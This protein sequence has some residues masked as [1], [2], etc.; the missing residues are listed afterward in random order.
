MKKKKL[1]K[2]MSV[3]LSAAMLA[4]SV[5]TGV[6]AAAPEVQTSQEKAADENELKLWYDEKAPDSYE[7]WYRRALP[8]GNSGIGASVFGGITE[9]RIQLNEKS[10]WSGGPSSSRN[11]NGGNIETS[12]GVKMSDIVTQIQ[13]A[14][15]NGEVD[16]GSNNNTIKNLCNKLVGLSDDAGTNG[17]GYYLSYG[18]MYLDFKGITESYVSNYKRALDLH[19]AVASVEYDYNGTHYVRENF[20]SYPDNVLVTRLTATGGS[21]KLNFDVKVNPDDKKG[22][23]ANN[24]GASSYQRDWT[25]TVKGGEI[26]VAGALKD[27]QMKFN[28]QT[29]VI[30][31]DGTTTDGT[32]KVTVADATSVTIIT[33]IATDYKDEYPKYRTDESADVL[34]TRVGSYVSKAAAKDYDTLKA[35][36]VADYQNIF[37]RVD[38]DLGQI[39]SDKTTD[40]LLSAYKA[41]TATDAE[42]RYLEVMLFQY[43][44]YLTIE[45]SRETPEDDP[46]R[47]T[48][49]SNLQGIWS[50]AN[51]SPWHSD[52]HMNVNL[53]M[54]YW[55]TYVTNM[56]E[57]AEPLIDYVDALRAPGRVT[58]KIYA[59]VESKDGEENGFM[60]HTQ[61]NPFGWTCPGWSFSWGWSPAAVPWI[62]QNCW[63][64]Y[65]FTRDADYLKDKIYPMM[66]E[67]ATFYDQILIEDADG[68]LVSSPSYSPEH[69]RYTSGNTYEQTLVWQ[70][71]EDTI[72]AAG[73][74]GETNTDK[75][76]K[77]K[78]NQSNLKGPIEVGKSGQ[79]KEWYNETTFNKDENG[80]NLGEGYGHRHIS[81][82]LGLFPG[83]LITA[84]KADWF[85]A[86]KVSMENRTDESTGW[87]MAQRINTWARLGEG[88][89]AYEIIKNQFK[90]GIYENLFDYHQPN[91]FQIDGNFGYTSGVAEMLLQSNMG[92]INLLPALPDTWSDGS[93]EGLVARGNFELSYNWSDG[94]LNQAQILSNKGGECQVQYSGI[95]KA[96]VTDSEGNVV[97]ATKVD[98]KTNRIS[99]NT[100]A[101]KTYTIKVPEAPKNVKANYYGKS[102]T[103]VSWS[104]V[105]DATSYNVYR[106]E[107]GM[108]F[109]KVAENTKRT[110][111]VDSKA[112]ADVATVSYK[113]TAVYGDKESGDS[114]VAA[115]KDL[116]QSSEKLAHDGWKA[117]A[118]SE[119]NA[120]NDG[121][122][123]W[124]IDGNTTTIWHSKWSSGGTH[125]DIAN[126]QNNEFTIDFGQNVTINKFEYVP[127]SSGTSV[128]GIITKYKLLYSTTESG[129]D[130]KELTSGEWDADKTVKTATFAPTEMRR[131]QIRALATLDDTATKNQHVTAAE[132]NAYKYIATTPVMIDTDALWNAVLAAQDKDLSIYTDATAKAYQDA[133]DAAK[134]KL[135]LELED[136]MTQ[137][138]V[139]N[140]LAALTAAITGLKEKPD[141]GSLTT[142][143][144]EAGKT[145]LNGYTQET[146]NAFKAALQEA[147]NVLNDEKATKEQVEKALSK[148]NAAQKALKKETTPDNDKTQPTAP[149]TDK[150][151]PAPETK[152]PAVGTTVTVK[153]VQYAVTKSAA[154]GGT[155]EAV[156]V[157]GKGKKITIAATVKIEGVTFKVTS[158]RKNAAK[159]NSRIT[160]VV[161]GKNVT[162]IGAGSFE[163]CKKLAN[164]TFKGTK[165]VKIGKKAFKGTSAKM[166]VVTAKKMPKKA[167]GKLK[168]TLKK[169]GISKKAVYKKK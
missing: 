151:N 81:H 12:G 79:I 95:A 2:A 17:Y 38:L 13:Q 51:N 75:V 136:D 130:F 9:E 132:F 104:A 140:A 162:S 25:T 129:N 42:R 128:N 10:L 117:T 156:K 139:N 99:F 119:E 80:N 65:D 165:A 60:A 144:A 54:N 149:G 71:Y 89:K 111:F 73:I 127:R 3:A 82:M 148:L 94:N 30:A 113:V 146:V 32:D 91:F 88:N 122:A 164:V 28:S 29:K 26:T 131:I 168:K 143:V 49:P 120:G 124:A 135:A 69:G 102:G 133:L 7:G 47:E 16:N 15:A 160:S 152:V 101:G 97:G 90:G 126:D 74:V 112:F 40:E 107:D 61:N 34:N 100:E 43:G 109:E 76:A 85:A 106:S 39:P 24:P 158:I 166:K 6:F 1:W 57:C 123:S 4:T 41:G 84:D 46:Y 103:K 115:V 52:Y 161:I 36:H 21:G 50:G 11:Y 44:R 134:A 63:E 145:D 137:E 53:Q 138:Q 105:E 83:D 72:E 33:S 20:V 35:D 62:L 93:V 18:N 114:K 98:G 64:Y 31:A 59:G 86:A 155:A 55:P 157:T 154:Q 96:T 77:W 58:A 118:G 142:A 87:G 56:A 150:T 66:K 67:E 167:L 68:K 22:N 45:S 8:L 14:F 121:P 108:T 116:T 147:Q 23:A 153:G 141:K 37:E 5:P 48:L 163:K 110:S 70:L 159:K 125:P 169:N 19:T 27:N 78:E 92:Y